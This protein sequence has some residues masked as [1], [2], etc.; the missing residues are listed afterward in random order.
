MTQATETAGAPS[1]LPLTGVRV[2]DMSDGKG[3]MC[4]RLLADLGADVV[5]I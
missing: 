1:A 2:V 4:G 5:L 3:E